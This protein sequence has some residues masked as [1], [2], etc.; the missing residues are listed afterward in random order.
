MDSHCYPNCVGASDATTTLQVERSTWIAEIDRLKRTVCEKDKKI[1]EL[2]EKLTSMTAHLIQSNASLV[3]VS[4][5]LTSAR[6]DTVKLANR[7]ADITQAIVAKPS[8]EECLHSLVMHSMIS[9]RDTVTN[10]SQKRSI[11]DTSSYREQNKRSHCD[12]DK[13][14][15]N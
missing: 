11:D 13:R 3:S 9:G 14:D 15:E 12:G 10:R 1:A 8:V 7:I 2:N 4:N 6:R 5:D